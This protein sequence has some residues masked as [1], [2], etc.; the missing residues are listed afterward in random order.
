M[1]KAGGFGRWSCASIVLRCTGTGHMCTSVT[2]STCIITE[3]V[4]HELGCA[5][6]YDHQVIMW[7]EHMSQ[8][9]ATI[10]SK[11]HPVVLALIVC[12]TERCTYFSPH[13]SQ[14]LCVC[15]RMQQWMASR[16][17]QRIAFSTSCHRKQSQAV[18]M[19]HQ[20]P[21]YACIGVM[22]I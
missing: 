14:G 16:V 20:A 18:C 12:T 2:G 5:A 13:E 9:A 10:H 7:Y 17:L 15:S 21:R 3:A 6:S 1:G 19:R 8:S 22:H 11:C 4:I